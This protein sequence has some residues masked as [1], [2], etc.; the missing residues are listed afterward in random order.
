MGAQSA[1]YKSSEVG[2]EEKIIAEVKGE[3]KSEATIKVRVPGFL[4]LGA[5]DGYSL[6]GQT[7]SHPWNHYGTENTLY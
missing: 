2:G 4:E 7:G 1:K 6:I 5:G 3:K